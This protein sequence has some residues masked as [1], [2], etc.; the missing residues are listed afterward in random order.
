[1]LYAGVRVGKDG[2]EVK[3][4][5]QLRA[6]DAVARHIGMF[7]SKVELTGKDG[8]PVRHQNVPTDLS[9]LSDDELAHLE[10]IAA[11]LGHPAGP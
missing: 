10:A 8:G 3:M 7:P 6:L 4:H 1:L 2:L 5:D 11:K 9:N